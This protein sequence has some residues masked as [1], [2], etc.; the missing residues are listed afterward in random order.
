MSRRWLIGRGSAVLVT[1]AVVGV[2][3]FGA[4]GP[5]RAS[6]WEE[7]WATGNV[8][9]LRDWFESHTGP[10][11][12]MT[13]SAPGGEIRTQE[14]ADRLIGKVITSALRVTCDCVVQEFVLQD[15]DLSIID[16]KVTVANVTL[17]GRDTAD[18]IGALSAEGDAEVTL[19]HVQIKGHHDGIRAYARTVKGKYVYVH[20]VSRRNPHDYHQDGIQTIGGAT[21]SKRSFIDMVGANTS[22]VFVKPDA[23]PIRYARINESVV[24]GGGYTFH[25][26]DGPKGTPQLV[27]LSN[28]LVA[29]GYRDGLV[30]TWELTDPSRAVPL[31]YARGRNERPGQTGR[32]GHTLM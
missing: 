31:A 9:V 20:D 23:S 7:V 6:T 22:A 17:D 27:D 8:H 5:A 30:S 26:H 3:M 19:S 25:A 15:A 28:N 14:D 2:A 21:A 10:T 32:R 11:Q 1:V 12:P 29:P 18:T 4:I 16:G 24:M 13:G